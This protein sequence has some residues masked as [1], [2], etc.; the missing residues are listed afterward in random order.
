MTRMISDKINCISDKYV[1]GSD[2]CSSRAAN[3]LSRIMSAMIQA[4]QC[5]DQGS[6]QQGNLNNQQGNNNLP[7]AGN[8]P[9]TTNGN[10]QRGSGFSSSSS[11]NFNSFQASNNFPQQSNLGQASS[12]FSFSS[13]GTATT[14]PPWNKFKKNSSDNEQITLAT[15]GTL[16]LITWLL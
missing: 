12:T 4:V 15:L 13:P 9:V 14:I 3:H 16:L 10:P 11:N 6:F 8:F 1:R 2:F 5:G 7:Q